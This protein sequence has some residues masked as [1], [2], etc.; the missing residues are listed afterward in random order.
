MQYGVPQGSILGPLLFI[1]YINDIPNVSKIA[2]FVMYA[3]DA[4]VLLT[5]KT[6][7]DIERKFNELSKHLETWVNSNGLPFNLKKTHL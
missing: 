7:V 1:I 5:G 2:K 4:N 6:V 3:D